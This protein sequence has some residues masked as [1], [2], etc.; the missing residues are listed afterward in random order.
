MDRECVAG[1]GGTLSAD[2]REWDTLSVNVRECVTMTVG[3]R[4]WRPMLGIE[5]PI[6][7]Q[8]RG[9]HS[10]MTGIGDRC[11]GLENQSLIPLK[12]GIGL[13]IPVSAQGS[14]GFLD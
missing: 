9:A 13:S 4:E 11:Q 8:S 12:T 2:G 14:G 1:I 10:S 3:V 7:T 6:L 5:K